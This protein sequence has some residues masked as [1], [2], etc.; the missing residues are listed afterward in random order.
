M[1]YEREHRR[2]AA[3]R[4]YYMPLHAPCMYV[5]VNECLRVHTFCML[6]RLPALLR[7]LRSQKV[8]VRLFCHFATA[9]I[10]VLDESEYDRCSVERKQHTPH[11]PQ[12]HCRVPYHATTPHNTTHCAVLRRLHAAGRARPEK[13]SGFIFD[14]SEA[15]HGV[16]FSFLAD[17]LWSGRVHAHNLLTPTI[18]VKA[19][20]ICEILIT[21]NWKYR[22]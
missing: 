22:T 18:K 17:F 15:V 3:A 9:C 14:S 2:S 5:C 16:L 12:C 13:L 11:H 21:R 4:W 1:L 19:L 10:I 7:T 8:P 20:S 6:L